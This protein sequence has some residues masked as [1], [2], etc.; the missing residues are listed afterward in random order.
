[1]L[2]LIHLRISY[3]RLPVQYLFHAALG[4]DVVAAANS[5]T[6]SKSAKQPTEPV[7]RYVGIC[8]AAQ[9]LDEKRIAFGRGRSLPEALRKAERERNEKSPAESREQLHLA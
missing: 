7:K 4:E 5:L 1:M 2:D 8:I 6:E 3:F 9:D